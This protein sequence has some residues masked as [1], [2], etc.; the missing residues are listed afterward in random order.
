MEGLAPRVGAGRR[1]AL[2][3]LALGLIQCLSSAKEWHLSEYA[4]GLGVDGVVLH[5]ISL[6][7]TFIF[8]KMHLGIDTLHGTVV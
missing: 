5:F 6:F 2:V 8:S 3:L 1:H 4:G 7:G